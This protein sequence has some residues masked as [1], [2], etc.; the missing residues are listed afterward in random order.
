MIVAMITAS[1]LVA[2]YETIRRLV[3]P[4][5]VEFLGAVMVASVM[6]FT[7][8]RWWLSSASG[9]ADRS[10]S[11]APIA[12]DCHVRVDGWTSLV[13]IGAIDV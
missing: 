4:Q 11:V 10:A 8:T 5:P 1:A 3:H 2:S 12:D 6:G 9:W 7:G 13:L